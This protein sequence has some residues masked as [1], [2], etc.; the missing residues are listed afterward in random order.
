MSAAA[1][2][3][4][5]PVTHFVAVLLSEPEKWL[6]DKSYYG[7][8]LQGLS[9]GLLERGYYMRPIDCLHEY[10][11]AHFLDSS[12]G[13]YAGA[14]FLGPTYPFVDFIRRAAERVP[15]PKVLLDHHIEGMG[16]HSIRE[17]AEAGMGMVVRHLVDLGHRSLAYL[18]LEDPGANP[19]KRRAIDLAL[20][21]AGLPELGAGRVAGCR[22]SFLDAAKA[23]EWLLALSP[24][25]TAVLCC[26]DIR[27]LLLLQ[28]A[29]EHSL[30]VP[31]DLS[32]TGFGDAAVR[33]G[34]SQILT[35]VSVDPAAMGRKAAEII[36][37]GKDGGPRTIL[38]RP[39]L[40][41]RGSTARPAP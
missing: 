12:S 25:P 27:A 41:V 30:R 24:R 8:M 9:E 26:D 15:G 16:I 13:L 38:I 6:N 40:V 3:D 35:S 23:L 4:R 7:P 29:A 32:I 14:V 22:N 10:Q 39:E 18:D 36:A 2:A 1:A 5:S 20:Q 31:H 28:A 17:D 33:S 21:D 11:R 19:W 34:R 37:A